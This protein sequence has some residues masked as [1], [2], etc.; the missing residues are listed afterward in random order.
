MQLW[1]GCS[2]SPVIHVRSIFMC[3]P[4]S[5]A[6]HIH[7]RSI[8]VY[9]T[10]LLYM[11]MKESRLNFELFFLVNFVRNLNCTRYIILIKGKPPEYIIFCNLNS[12]FDTRE[13]TW[14]VFQKL[15]VN[16]NPRVLA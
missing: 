12:C 4:Y 2:E 3:G 1:V 10:C 8:H 6:V 9:Y 14:I 13:T 15:S 11:F 7:G 16:L 5:C